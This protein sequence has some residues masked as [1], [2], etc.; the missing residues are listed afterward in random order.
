VYADIVEPVKYYERGQTQH[1]TSFTSLNRL[2]DAARPESD[3][4]RQFNQ[5]VDQALSNRA[6]MKSLALQLRKHL[7]LWRDNHVA[8]KPVLESSFLLKEI[9]PVSERISAVAAAG[10]QA[11]DSIESG[12][13]PAESWRRSQIAMLDKAQKAQAEVLIMIVPGIKKLVEATIPAR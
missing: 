3:S 8:L 4:G 13:R 11:L 7:T 1:Y 10:L 6:S 9:I 2:V 12:Q 5:W